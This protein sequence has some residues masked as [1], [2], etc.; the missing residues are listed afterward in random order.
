M[1]VKDAPEPENEFA[2]TI[3]VTSRLLKVGS[4]VRVSVAPTPDAVTIR[5]G[6]TKFKC[7]TLPAVPTTEPSSFTTRPVITPVT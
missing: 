4:S 6:L 7:A 2:V 3:P 1:F 5:L